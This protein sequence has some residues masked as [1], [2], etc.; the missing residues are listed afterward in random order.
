MYELE[1]N[2]EKA[3][4]YFE[5]AAE[6]F[7]VGGGTTTANQCKLKGAQFC[8]QLEQYVLTY[9]MLISSIVAIRDKIP[10]HWDV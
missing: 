7:E 9:A 2:N 10:A 1:K 5:R 3:L 6:L 8:A 4:T